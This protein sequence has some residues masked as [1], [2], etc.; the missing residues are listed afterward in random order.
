MIGPMK[1]YPVLSE[2]LKTKGYTAGMTMEINMAEKNIV[3][4]Q[5]VK[6][7]PVITE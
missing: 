3:F 5:F 4:I 6:E 1:A 2:Y 7:N